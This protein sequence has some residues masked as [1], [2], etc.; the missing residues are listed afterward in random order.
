MNAVNI[1]MRSILPSSCKA[2]HKADPGMDK[3]LSE[4]Y[5][6]SKNVS[7]LPTSSVCVYVVHVS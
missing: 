1:G 6:D 7:Y 2:S 3:L 5:D 4:I